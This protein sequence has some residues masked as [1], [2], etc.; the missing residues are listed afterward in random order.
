MTGLK[1]LTAPVRPR[2]WIGGIAGV[3][4]I[5][6]LGLAAL[7]ATA[8]N[9]AAAESGKSSSFQPE[10]PS[11]AYL[12]GR[13]AEGR[14]ALSEAATLY[15]RALADDPDNAEL[16]ARTLYLMVTVGR[17]DAALPLARRVIAKQPQAR[18]ANLVLAV[19]AAK[20]KRYADALGHLQPQPKRGA[21]QVLIPLMQAWL[22]YGAGNRDKALRTLRE[23]EKVAG[24]ANYY[25]LH[26]GLMLEMAGRA[27][28]AE[29]SYKQALADE[30]RIGLRMIEAIGVFYERTGRPAEAAALYQKYQK[31][32][33]DTLGLQLALERARRGG[34]AAPFLATP[35]EGVAEALFDVASA[36]RRGRRR[37][38]SLI[39]S[40]L[41]LHLK[42]DFGPAMVLIAAVL[43]ERGQRAAAV[44]LYQAVPRRSPL[45]WSARLAAAQALN[46]I[47]RGAEAARILQAMAGERPKRFDA[48]VALGDLHRGKER[49][50]Q[51]V[52]A[53]DRAFARIPKIERRHWG[54]L[55]ARGIALERSKQWLRAEKDFLKALEFE[56]NQP[57]VLNYLGYSWVEQGKN[58]DRARQ[59]IEKAVSLRRND[60]YITDSLGWVLYKI[61][62]FKEAVPH[63]ERA[64]ALRPQDPTINDHLGDAYWMVGRHR[65]AEFQWRRALSLKPEKD[66]IK[67][68]EAKIKDGLKKPGKKP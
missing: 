36:V 33:P 50:A 20:R 48:L 55:Y 60:G 27:K 32:T 56:P 61:A 2:G 40:R 66:Q 38:Q 30:A 59:M 31:R 19:D 63:L 3:A 64:V 68:I 24:F 41:A 52:K 18:L 58:L 6:S 47:D 4:A 8:Q 10:T 44:R 15:A 22:E 1:H 57:F 14:F 28:A 35:G 13:H 26:S 9:P 5:A 46:R 67:V 65:E 53:Y 49:F 62:K 17:I 23:V 16:L 21:N 54:L 42:P 25:Y 29:A 45:S 43:D 37:R 39:Y 12:A 7:G 34:K 11:G 51:S